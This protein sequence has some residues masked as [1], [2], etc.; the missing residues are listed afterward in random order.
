MSTLHE[1]AAACC[2]CLRAHW[3]TTQHPG[4][5]LSGRW[6][7][8]QCAREFAPGSQADATLL[9]QLLEV[10][11]REV[12]KTGGSEGAV[13]VAERLIGERDQA[14]AELAAAEQLVEAM[15]ADRANAIEQAT[16]AFM[17]G[18]TD[19]AAAQRA[20]DA[21]RI[22]WAKPK[23]NHEDSCE[24]A[25]ILVEQNKLVTTP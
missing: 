24:G 5:E 7:C 13:E 4:G 8:T 19:G 10:L 15:Q 2:A 20:S 6:L 12:G 14:L 3:V 18:M 21:A 23:F 11:G 1:A 9:A 25:A 16:T 17:R 22:R